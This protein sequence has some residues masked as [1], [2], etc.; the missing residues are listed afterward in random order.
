M[1]AVG[2]GKKRGLMTWCRNLSFNNNTKSYFLYILLLW[3]LINRYILIKLFEGR[4][5]PEGHLKGN[6]CLNC[7][8]VGSDIFYYFG[9]GDWF[10][11]SL[12]IRVYNW[13]WAQSSTWAHWTCMVKAL[14]SQQH[15]GKQ[16]DEYQIWS[17]WLRTDSQKAQG[18]IDSLQV[19]LCRLV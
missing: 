16:C 5:L 1:I 15:T 11:F 10:F 8:V 2:H 3:F 19:G 4:K 9:P 7:T 12:K 17:P 18:F 6:S 13:R 14:C